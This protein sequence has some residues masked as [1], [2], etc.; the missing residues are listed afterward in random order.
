MHR[1]SGL[2][3]LPLLASSAF[4]AT[5]APSAPAQSPAVR[6]GRRRDRGTVELVR[7]L[8]N[9][10]RYLDGLRDDERD[11][12]PFRLGSLDCRL[13]ARPDY[14][15]RAMLNDDWPPISRGRLMG[16]QK[17][18]ATGLFLSYG[19]EHHRQRDELWKPLFELPTIP[20][21]A[22]ARTAERLGSWRA[23]D[24]IEMYAELRSLCWSIDWEALTGTALEPDVLRALERGVDA[25]AWLI[26]PLGQARWDWPLPQS[27]HTREARRMLDA[28][29]AAMVAER[30]NGG[31]RDDLL[32]RL[33]RQADEDGV[34]T[35][36]QL[37]ATVKMWFGADQ[38]HALF[39]WTL[40]LLAQHREIEEAWH[41]ELDAVLDGRTATV[42]DIAALRLTRDILKESMRV[43]PPV[44]GFF[45]QL[46]DDY[47]LGDEVVPKGHVMA[48]SPWFTHRD[49]RLWPDPL[50]F[51][52]SRWADG[53]ERPPEL[54]YFPFSAG[55][56]E[57]HGA[58]LAMKEAVLVL[59]TLGQRWSFRT[60]SKEPKPFATWATEPKRGLYLLPVPRT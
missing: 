49:P 24:A 1:K 40:Y 16:L 19:Q 60:T 39:T 28:R 22:V 12:I 18:Y 5:T 54:S 25:L 13:V 10:L 34:T 53:A 35:D 30:R 9:P 43:Y 38:L 46:T 48:M 36:A 11:L 2:S 7:F 3:T 17:W 45:R 8:S 41:A 6:G 55:P 33:V 21:L 32:S 14:L 15:K 4:V 57:C 51:D 52:P 58:G 47:P 42:G 56:Y 23:G 44:W 26:L 27:R 50:R 29:I 59:A 20:E 31:G 37:V